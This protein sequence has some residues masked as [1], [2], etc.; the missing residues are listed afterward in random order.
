MEHGAGVDGKYNQDLD[1][2]LLVV[3]LVGIGNTEDGD[4]FAQFRGNCERQL[5]LSLQIETWPKITK[6][7]AVHCCS[8][9]KSDIEL[10]SHSI[11]GF[12]D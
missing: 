8:S 10:K 3:E 2:S 12:M 9:F 11:N 6:E 4:E 5:Q 7:C 1:K